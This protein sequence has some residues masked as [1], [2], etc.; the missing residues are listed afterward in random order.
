MGYKLNLCTAYSF[1][2]VFTDILGLSNYCLGGKTTTK[3]QILESA[4]PRL[5]STYFVHTVSPL[6]QF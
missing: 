2:W 5:V 3:I 4:T 1:I 6:I